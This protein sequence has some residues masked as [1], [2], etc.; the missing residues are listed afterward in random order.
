[1]CALLQENVGGST[2]V[3]KPDVKGGKSYCFSTLKKKANH[4][5]SFFMKVD[6]LSEMMLYSVEMV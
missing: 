2:R 3:V 4:Y 6:F 1:V 5:F